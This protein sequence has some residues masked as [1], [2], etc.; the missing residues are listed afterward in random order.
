MRRLLL[1]LL[2]V[3]AALLLGC[4][5]T[6]VEREGRR[7]F[8]PFYAD[9]LDARSRDGWQQPARVLEALRL[10]P[11]A[12]VADIG[13]G[14]GYF[15]E[16]LAR[17]LAPGGG[18]VYATDVQPEMLERLRERVTDAGLANVEVVDAAYD[19][20]ALPRR[21]CDLVLFSSVYK[22]IDARVGYMEKVRA[23]L[24]PGGRVA[25]LEFRPEYR[26][27]GPPR[28]VRLPAEQVTR[29]LAAAG[30]TLREEHDFLPREYFLVFA[31]HDE[32]DAAD[33][34]RP[35][36]ARER[37]PAGEAGRAGEI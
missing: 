11:D 30:F 8:N 34:T 1:G 23:L 2:S 17:R 12:V 13:A 20:P 21:C 7:V 3:L 22:E 9:F 14:S 36:T 6:M 27:A 19:D 24:R 5:P 35:A 4:P 15:T 16:R 29:E 37:D 26:G 32:H 25:I 10:A 28:A 33:T 18:R 31:E